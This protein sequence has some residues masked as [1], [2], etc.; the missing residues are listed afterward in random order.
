[1]IIMKK[2]FLKPITA[3]AFAAA[4]LIGC[5]TADNTATY[6][7]PA[8]N[9][10][11]VTNDVERLSNEEIDY[12]D[13]FEN[14]GD[15]EQYTVLELARMNPKLSTFVE[16]VDL[17][18]LAPSLKIVDPVTVFVPT[19]EAFQELPA[20][21]LAELRSPENRTDLLKFIQAHILPNAHP[22]IGMES[23]EII[24]TEGEQSI[25]INKTLNGTATWVGG[26]KIVKP[27]VEASNGIIHV[28]GSVIKPE[29][30][31]DRINDY[32]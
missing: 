11:V 19:N 9:T 10:A 32:K 5:S 15:T 23:G 30:S 1:M 21:R 27:D 2:T 20:A 18:G 29:L 28:V 26:A 4:T 25:A 17:S 16:L 13:M 22:A 7:E 14:V 6:E 12:D 8:G 3:M 31:T 24:E